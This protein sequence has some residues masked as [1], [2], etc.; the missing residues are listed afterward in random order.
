MTELPSMTKSIYLVSAISHF[1]RF[2]RI[3]S[4]HAAF[5]HGIAHRNGE[6]YPF[7]SK[8]IDASMESVAP[9]TVSFN[10]HR[11]PDF[12][13]PGGWP[14]VTEVFRDRLQNVPNL[15]TNPIL[16][17]K[18]TDYPWEPGTR[19]D[20][21][22]DSL[23]DRE[24]F[25]KLPSKEPTDLRVRYELITYRHQLVCKEFMNSREVI[26]EVGT[27]P[28]VDE[29]EYSYSA[30]LLDE[31][32]IHWFEGSMVFAEDVWERVSELVDREFFIVRQYELSTGKL[33]NWFGPQQALNS[34]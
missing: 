19:I 14:V 24:L 21:R 11:V 13:K 31:Y 27:P 9:I 16:V 6:W 25:E 7:D 26:L 3:R 10:Q 20:I 23:T 33:L 34:Q 22:P 8:G 5:F 18:V 29:C 28:G 30:E 17:G 1:L 4:Y 32:P 15:K 12:C 2:P